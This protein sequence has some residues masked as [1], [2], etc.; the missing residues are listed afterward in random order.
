M[1]KLVSVKTDGSLNISVENHL[2]ESIRKAH[3]WYT[4]KYINVPALIIL[5]IIDIVGFV[6]IMNLTVT[7]S[8]PSRVI[9]TSALA[10]AFD[11]APL[12]I[13]YALCLKAYELGKAIH[14]W[15][16][17][18]ST[19]ACI[20]G[21]VGNIYFRF[22]TMNIAYQGPIDGE[23][24]D[25][26][27]PLTVLMCILPIIT[28]LVNL[29]IGCLTFDPL[30]FD[31]LRLSKKLRLLKLRKRQVEAY[32]EEFTDENALKQILIENENRCYENTKREIYMLR[33][34]LKT[35]TIAKISGAHTQ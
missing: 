33:S 13:G 4:S 19:I 30:L 29:T 31:M 26:A 17:G 16:L 21:V 18:F 22:K 8:L 14:N 5:A 7:E 35:Y 1:S 11:V 3:T 15:I 12:Y 9:I 23:A 34:K 2:F 24:S 27:L 28:S 32:L 25:L 20:L 10:I 6:Q